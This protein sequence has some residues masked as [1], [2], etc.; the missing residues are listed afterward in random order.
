MLLLSTNNDHAN[1]S[2]ETEILRFIYSG[3]TT[4]V[5]L[6]RIDLARINGGG[7]YSANFYINSN[8]ILPN[9]PIEID[10]GRNAFITQSKEIIIAPN[11]LVSL[12]VFGLS[13]DTDVSAKAF[14][15]DIGSLPTDIENAINAAI[16]AGLKDT[17]I[18]PERTVLG[19]CI[20]PTR[21]SPTP[22]A[23]GVRTFR[24][25]ISR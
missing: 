2:S 13:Q 5:A 1:I 6:A 17:V 9:F 7:I 4:T 15:Y 23:Q 21:A 11:D 8:K 12:R 10:A 14:L 22:I 3:T 20:E 19:P 24:K 16:R 25:P 18:N